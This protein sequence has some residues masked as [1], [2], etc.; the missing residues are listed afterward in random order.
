[1][2]SKKARRYDEIN[3]TAWLEFT[4][5]P[6]VEDLVDSQGRLKSGYSDF[7]VR[8]ADDLGKMSREE[9]MSII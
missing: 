7:E 9:L 6:E 1:M 3:D 4:S 2:R 5:S 8:D